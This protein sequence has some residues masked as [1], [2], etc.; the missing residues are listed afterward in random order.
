MLFLQEINNEYIN[1]FSISIFNC[2]TSL[3]EDIIKNNYFEFINYIVNQNGKLIN[4]FLYENRNLQNFFFKSENTFESCEIIR[5]IKH[6]LKDF[7]S[8]SF[9]IELSNITDISNLL[10]IFY[11]HVDKILLLIKDFFEENLIIAYSISYNSIFKRFIDELIK[12]LELFFED[13]YTG[14]RINTIWL[15]ARSKKVNI[16]LNIN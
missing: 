3:L 15:Q 10:Q 1:H 16:L 14:F 5:V 12:I 11:S 13:L 4:K 9:L 2:C 7:L 8:I 6:N